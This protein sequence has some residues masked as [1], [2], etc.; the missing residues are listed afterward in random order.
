MTISDGGSG[1]DAEE[2]MKGRGIGITS[3]RERLKL[4][5]GELSIDSEPQ[6]GTVV[7]AK[8]PIRRGTMS[9]A[10]GKNGG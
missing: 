3:M 7:H 2:A 6:R 5:E 4:V 1:F 8:V 10:A 9:A